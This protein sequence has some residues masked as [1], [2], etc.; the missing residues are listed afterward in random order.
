VL[1]GGCAPSLGSQSALLNL[2]LLCT[3][4]P[5]Y[6]PLASR[7]S[8]RKYYT[9]LD[10]SP[11]VPGRLCRPHRLAAMGAAGMPPLAPRSMGPA[12]P[13]NTTRYTVT[14][15]VCAC[16]ARLLLPPRS[17]ATTV[18]IRVPDTLR[19]HGPCAALAHC[20][21]CKNPL[22]CARAAPHIVSPPVRGTHPARR[23][24]ASRRPTLPSSHLL[25]C[26]YRR[27]EIFPRHARWHQRPRACSVACF[28]SRPLRTPPLRATCIFSPFRLGYPCLFFLCRRIPI[29]SNFACSSLVRLLQ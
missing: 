13:S 27:I 8:V 12:P 28:C 1:L 9:M 15:H 11:N 16:R 22:I 18:S 5:T 26:A 20:V 10:Y 2:G 3:F 17:T 25:L 14:M 21:L 24:P 7:I 4:P 6:A 29:S 19:G 23:P